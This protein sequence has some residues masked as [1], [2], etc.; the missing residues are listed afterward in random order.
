MKRSGWL[1]LFMLW[2]CHWFTLKCCVSWLLAPGQEIKWHYL[3]SDVTLVDL[4]VVL[5]STTHM[6]G[7]VCQADVIHEQ[8][9]HCGSVD[10]LAR[11]SRSC[12][13]RQQANHHLFVS[14]TPQLLCCRGAHCCKNIKNAWKCKIIICSSNYFLCLWLPIFDRSAAQAALAEDEISHRPCDSPSV[15]NKL[16]VNPARVALANSL[17]LY[18]SS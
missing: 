3:V 7:S 18:P 9:Y 15:V 17:S 2:T 5:L 13:W 6:A 12:K 10:S 14:T 4:V 11:S 8:F 1:W 16:G